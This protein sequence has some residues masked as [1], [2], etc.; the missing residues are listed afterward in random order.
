[1]LK[2]S[3]SKT[4]PGEGGVGVGGSI[5]RRDKS[6]LDGRRLDDDKV[7]SNEIGDNEVE[8][9]VQK[10]SKSKKPESGFFTPG[11]RKA[12]MKLRQAFIKAPILDH[13]DPECYIR[14]E[15]DTSGYA[16]GRV[17][18]QLTLDDLGQ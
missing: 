8:T 16:I 1:M 7:D 10:L 9:K 2:T 11:A 13:F 18:S 15:T 5:A 6:K 12:F 17:L 14:V 4:R 3:E